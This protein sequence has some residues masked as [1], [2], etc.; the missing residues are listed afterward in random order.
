MVGF[1]LTLND[2]ARKH[3][4]KSF[5]HLMLI[6]RKTL[7]YTQPYKLTFLCIYAR[8]LST[9]SNLLDCLHKCLKNVAYKAACTVE[10]S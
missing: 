1:L 2:N 10:S 5:E 3:E 9:S 4:L 8:I 6:I 7:L